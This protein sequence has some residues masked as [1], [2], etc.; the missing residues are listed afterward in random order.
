MIIEGAQQK[1]MVFLHSTLKVLSIPH[2]V[3]VRQKRFRPM[4][5]RVLWASTG[6]P[7]EPASYSLNG[8]EIA[9]RLYVRVGGRFEVFKTSSKSVKFWQKINTSKLLEI[10]NLDCVARNR[11]LKV[12]TLW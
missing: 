7:V 12:T 9:L 1:L 5:I 11:T 3:F 10:Y 4:K 8:G 2:I 6:V